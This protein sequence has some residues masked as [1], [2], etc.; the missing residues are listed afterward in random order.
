MTAI[1]Y[2]GRLAVTF[3]IIAHLIRHGAAVTPSSQGEGFRTSNARP[4]ILNLGIAAL[5]MTKNN[6]QLSIFNSQ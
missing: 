6:S 2:L 3:F 1:P 4:Y 5:A